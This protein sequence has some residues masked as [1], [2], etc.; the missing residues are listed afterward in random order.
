MKKIWVYLL[1]V[2]T[3][4]IVTTIA[5]VIIGAALYAKNDP[6]IRMTNGMSFFETPGDIIEPSSVKVFQAL[7]DGAALAHCK[8]KEKYDWYGDPVVLLYNEDGNP[9][10]DEQIINA[11]QGKCF[12]QIGIY[13][14]QAKS[15][16][17]KTVPIVMLLD[18]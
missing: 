13:R 3:G 11:T 4:I 18:K 7:G 12:R 17:D 16:M 1:G 5:F 15:G 14:Y 10:Y 6:G 8:G 2:L 9:Y